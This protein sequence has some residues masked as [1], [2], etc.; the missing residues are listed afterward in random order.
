MLQVCNTH[1][2]AILVANT[3]LAVSQC[4]LRTTPADVDRQDVH[5][6]TPLHF[7]ALGGRHD[8]AHMLLTYG[9]STSLLNK[10][11]RCMPGP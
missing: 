4:H 6:N 3:T 1:P 11:C 2:V 5:G 8:L 7:A 10:V 9:A